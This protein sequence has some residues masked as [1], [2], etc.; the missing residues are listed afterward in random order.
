MVP[1]IYHLYSECFHGDDMLYNYIMMVLNGSEPFING[2][3]GSFY[4]DGIYIYNYIYM[5]IIHIIIDLS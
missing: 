2:D 5:N 1:F 4:G 3:F